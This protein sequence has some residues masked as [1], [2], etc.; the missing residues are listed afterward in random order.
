MSNGRFGNR[1]ERRRTSDPRNGDGNGSDSGLTSHRLGRLEDRVGRLEDKVDGLVT[2][3]HDLELKVSDL[4]GKID[5]LPTK[6]YLSMWLVALLVAGF[7]T[8][9]GILSAN[10]TG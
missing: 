7:L 9:V 10:G 4:A 5:N 8:V 1:T 3:V 2:R 6:N